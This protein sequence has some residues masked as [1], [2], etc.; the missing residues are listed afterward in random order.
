[1]ITHIQ[2]GNDRILDNLYLK[3]LDELKGLRY[4][5]KMGD[6]SAVPDAFTEVVKVTSSPDTLWVLLVGFALQRQ[7]N[8]SVETPSSFKQTFFSES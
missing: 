2:K 1:M 5:G 8:G 4:L 7:N 3:Y 6:N